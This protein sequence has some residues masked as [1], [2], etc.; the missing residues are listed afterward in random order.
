MKKLGKMPIK[1]LLI[2]TIL[3]AILSISSVIYAQDTSENIIDIV[4]NMPKYYVFDMEKFNS[5]EYTIGEYAPQK[6]EEYI[7]Q[8]INDDSIDIKVDNLEGG[9]NFT[10]MEFSADINIFKDGILCDTVHFGWEDGS[11]I[12]M[13]ALITVPSAIEKT[14]E[15]YI[16]YAKDIIENKYNWP[17][18]YKIEK[19]V[20][21][22]DK[23][24]VLLDTEKFG[25]IKYNGEDIEANLY[26]FTPQDDYIEIPEPLMIMQ[27]DFIITYE[28]SSGA[29]QKYT[30]GES[31]TATFRINADYS[32]FENG[33]KVYVDDE[34]V[35]SS[36]Y[37][38]KSGSTVITFTKDYMSSLSEG[39][40]IL[41]VVFNNGGTSTTKFTIAKENL[42][43]TTEDAPMQTTET[44]EETKSSNPKTGD[45][46]IAVWVSLMFVSMLGIAGT[47]RFQRKANINSKK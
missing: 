47:V 36:N 11:Q 28:V 19:N 18:P 32:L 43:I 15:A 23:E 29:N 22:K 33:G 16:N 7:K 42:P 41:K 40:H 46:G 5:Q 10:F 17:L 45:N 25:T 14:E 30:T 9:G 13:F 31:N 20:Q 37:T 21:L 3:I 39:N 24:I 4:K 6:L 2:F 27:D 8:L 44:K 35:A 34:L 1:L 26:S 12:T 38:S